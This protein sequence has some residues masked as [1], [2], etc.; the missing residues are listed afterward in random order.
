MLD[1]FRFTVQGSIIL[2]SCESYQFDIMPLS[3][4]NFTQLILNKAIHSVEVGIG[5]YYI[6]RVNEKFTSE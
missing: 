6:S 4:I 2:R 3:R 1:I 5:S